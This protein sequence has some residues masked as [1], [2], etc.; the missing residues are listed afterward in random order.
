MM[1]DEPVDSDRWFA[2]LRWMLDLKQGRTH[3]EVPILN[4]RCEQIGTL[5]PISVKHFADAELLERFVRWRN[6]NL[7]GYLDQR[8]VTLE[9]VK[10]Y[11]EDVVYNPTR[12]TFLAYCDGQPIG[13]LGAVKIGPREHES[14]GLVRGERGGGM[15]F[16]HF[17]QITG[18]VLLF[19][20]FNQQCIYSR[21][22]SVND[23][24]LESCR[25]L[26]YSMQPISSQAIF[27][28]EHPNGFSLQVTG[29][30]AQR[31]EAITL[32]TYRLE[33]RSFSSAMRDHPNFASSQLVISELL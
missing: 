24:A 27:R 15:H 11:V 16:M 26:G 19:E 31:V 21:V 4:D 17:A 12:L 10:R 2:A 23:L 5:S 22:L 1:S 13:R 29:T 18:M 28:H 6:Q 32:D 30:D 3:L 25:K 20:A 14:D 7:S 9:G 8:P 33:R